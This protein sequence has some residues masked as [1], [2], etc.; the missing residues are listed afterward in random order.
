MQITITSHLMFRFWQWLFVINILLDNFNVVRLPNFIR[1]SQMF[2]ELEDVIFEYSILYVGSIDEWRGSQSNLLEGV[3]GNLQ[4]YFSQPWI[5]SPCLS[6]DRQMD[7]TRIKFRFLTLHRRSTSHH[8]CSEWVMPFHL[9]RD[10]TH[11]ISVHVC[12]VLMR[13]SELVA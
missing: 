9:A 6:S 10:I 5:Q 13:A 2:L 3:G 1:L 4:C 7:I 8:C 11:H 12:H